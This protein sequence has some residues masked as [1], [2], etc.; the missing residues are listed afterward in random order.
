MV[1][2]LMAP[3]ETKSE[4]PNFLLCGEPVFTNEIGFSQFTCDANI[5]A[6]YHLPSG[7]LSNVC[8]EN[9]NFKFSFEALLDNTTTNKIEV[10]IFDVPEWF[11]LLDQSGFDNG[12]SVTYS[13]TTASVDFFDWTGTVDFS[14]H[15]P[16][17]G[18][19]PEEY[20]FEISLGMGD[21]FVASSHGVG[22]E[23]NDLT[24]GGS[25]CHTENLSLCCSAPFLRFFEVLTGTNYVSNLTTIFQHPGC[26]QAD[27]VVVLNK[28]N[29]IFDVDYCLESDDTKIADLAAGIYMETNA[30]I[31]IENGNTVE[32]NNFL[33]SY[34][35][36][37]WDEIEV[38]DNAKFIVG[39]GNVI[40]GGNVG[41]LL[42]DGS[43][44]DIQDSE[45]LNCIDGVKTK[46]D[47][48]PI[49]TTIFLIIV[50][51]E[52]VSTEIQM[53]PSLKTII[54]QTPIMVCMFPMLPMLLNL[55]VV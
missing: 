38:E 53:L 23:V 9:N 51:R 28:G 20:C 48:R 3:F 44:L 26:G 30:K 13:H 31:T 54:L 29:L 49:L 27:P 37:F 16:G 42:K 34:C 2:I 39:N 18:Q 15:A 11:Y 24:N 14:N 35:D 33:V 8:Q 25:N 47:L 32:F 46:M 55:M 10:V 45:V 4:N 40:E 21:N 6:F 43:E 12:V 17:Q 19:D 41:I 5:E 1:S 22:V 52:S 50:K 36:A 7:Y